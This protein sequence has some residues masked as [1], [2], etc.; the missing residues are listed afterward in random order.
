MPA[1]GL[2]HSEEIV[3]RAIA[4]RRGEVIIATKC[5]LVWDEGST[6]I[7]GRLTAESVRR[8]AEAS[9]RR[10]K[11]EV[12]DLYQIHWPN[13]DEEVEEAWQAIADLVREGKVRFGGVCNFGAVE[14]GPADPPSGLTAAAV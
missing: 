11:A 13:P 4:G 12:M 3:G 2:G 8:E 6:G 1:Y 5:G 14:T 7:Y 10:L 9:L